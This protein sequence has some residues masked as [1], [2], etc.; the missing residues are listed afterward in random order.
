[1]IDWNRVAELRDE[2]G[3]DDFDEV[4]S[5]FLDEVEEVLRPLR[6]TPLVD[7]PGEILHFLKGSAWNLGFQALGKLCSEHETASFRSSDLSPIIAS[8]DT[9]R[10]VF[11][12][13]LPKAFAS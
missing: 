3:E 5:L 11:L 7:G 1:M 9:S 2:V 8:Y 6:E 12:S 10:A 13:G 4:V